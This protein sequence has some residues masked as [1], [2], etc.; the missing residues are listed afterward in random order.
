M[1]IIKITTNHLLIIISSVLNVMETCCRT[2]Y[3]ANN[4]LHG[5]AKSV[6]PVSN[7]LGGKAN[8]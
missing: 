6:H 3:F 8:V 1:K 4:L 7:A 2:K 5:S